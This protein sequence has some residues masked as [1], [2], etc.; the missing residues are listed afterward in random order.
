MNSQLI[1][2]P[3]TLLRQKLARVAIRLQQQANSDGSNVDYNTLEKS[4][5]EAIQIL[6]KFYSTLSSSSFA[7]ID[8]TPGAPPAAADFNHNI[9]DIQ[10]DLLTI[11]NEFENMEGVVLGEF[12]YLT[13][14]LN[15]LNTRIKSVASYLGDYAL[16]S[17]LATKDAIFFSDS[18]NSLQ[19]VEVD[20]PLLNKEQCEV[21][22]EEGIVTLPVNRQAQNDINITDIPVINSNSNGTV[23]NNEQLNTELHGS[24]ADILDKNADTWFEYERVILEDDGEA[25]VLD[26]TI[27][28]GSPKIINAITINPNNFGTKTSVEILNIDTASDGNIYTSIK[29]D[30]PIAGFTIEDEENVFLLAPATSKFSGQGIYTFTPRKAKY[31]HLTLKQS[32]PYLI[33]TADDILK[34]RYAIGIRDVIIEA[35]PY[36]EEGEIISTNYETTEEI[37]KVVLLCN[38]NPDPSTISAL[39][40]IDH[41]IS[42]DNGITWQQIRPKVSS[43]EANIV[44]TIP[45]LIDFN[46]YSDKTV[47]TS[48]P[49]Y[50]LRYKATLKRNTSAFN[51]DSAELAEEIVDS[52]ELHTPPSTTPFS[53]ALQQVPIKDTLRII[54]PNFG[55]CGYNERFYIGAG[56]GIATQMGGTQLIIQLSEPFKLDPWGYKKAPISRQIINQN[57]TLVDVA[58]EKIYIDGVRW[59][60]G[61]LT[62]TNTCYS[63]DRE[64][65]KITFG[66]GS[67]GMA[68]RLDGVIEMSLD[69]EKIYPDASVNH[70]AQLNFSATPKKGIEQTTIIDFSEPVSYTQV[71]N[72]GAYT[73]QLKPFIL[74]S[75]SGLPATTGVYKM[76]FS[77]TVVFA[78][79]Q[80]YQDGLAEFSDAGDFSVNFDTGIVV[81]KSATS[82]IADTYVTYTYTPYRILAD[83]EWGFIPSPNGIANALSIRDSSFRTYSMVPMSISSGVTYFVLRTGALVSGSLK[84]I[85]STTNTIPSTLKQEVPFIDGRTEFLNAIQ[86]SETM[87]PITTSGLVTIP[88]KM[89]ISTSTSLPVAFSQPDI[90]KVE[91]ATQG[92]VTSGIAGDYWI[93]RSTVLGSLT[94]GIYV[95]LSATQASPGIVHYYYTDPRAVSTGKYSVNNRTGEVYSYNTTGSNITAYCEYTNYSVCYHIAREVTLTDWEYDDVDNK[96]TIKDNEILKLNRIPQSAINNATSDRYYQVS[97]SYIKSSREAVSELEPYFSPILKNYALRVMTKSGLI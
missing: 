42:P 80:V 17:D 9:Q 83:D 15:R 81:T 47:I 39:A 22:Q 6:S 93:D 25:L 82:T 48:N 34:F 37:K 2:I 13:S 91:K 77:D 56:I 19:R 69:S 12:N 44:Q 86:T 26:I 85:D 32:T 30:I 43:G 50:S 59:T 78:D 23:G 28:L 51:Q 52:T 64:K 88:F 63:F 38:Q 35:L 66:D 65:G 45:E 31:V 67:N 29:D 73:H 74:G 36:R 84:F 71:L 79:P 20:S 40:S 75:T 46:G 60:N 96:I 49:V 62:G 21:N 33:V 27:N 95:K 5:S 4:V 57:G 90:F 8:A 53:I 10:D 18:F 1:Q 61:P 92:E 55:S 94:G 70:I 16:Y 41:F 89:K 7:P 3:S 68:P 87:S 97:Y 58:P 72:R 14:R 76:Y 24:I 11:F 54:D